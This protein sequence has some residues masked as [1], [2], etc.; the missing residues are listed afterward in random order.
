[1]GVVPI[2]GACTALPAAGKWEQITPKGVSLPRAVVIDPFDTATIWVGAAPAG[3]GQPAG[4]GGLYKSTDC[5][6]TW[7]HVNTGAHG[8]E[9]DNARLWS[10]AVDP[11]DKG[12][13]YVVGA[14]GPGGLWKSTNGGVDW[15][16][17]FPATS[18]LAKTVQ[19]NFV[20]SVS[21]GPENHLHLV[22]GTH[23]DCTGQY[24]P[25]CMAES[26]DGGATWKIFTT[27]FLKGWGEQTGPYVLDATTLVFQTLTD[28]LWLTTDHGANWT[29][30]TP[31]GVSGATGGE[32]THRPLAPSKD[33]SFYLPSYNQGGLLRSTDVGRS[34]SRVANAPH[35][36]YELGIA[37][38]GG[39]LYLGDYN[40][41]T[42]AVTKE[43]DPTVWTTIASPPPP[44]DAE[45]PKAL[46]Y[47]ETH[48]LLYSSN[49]S[50][51]LWR[52]VTP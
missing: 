34:W 22:V 4:Q 7:S 41:K 18:E 51:G 29:N 17:L 46:E 38:G 47:D 49:V 45:G 8:A 23:A 15:A 19:Y 42:Y 40:G 12:V 5:G 14:Y 32:Y 25:T 26:L 52:V 30:V 33:G 2:V 20:G 39:S 28:G 35:G 21:M 36:S 11:V 6:S 24:A 3:S 9:I 16:Q 27:P 44:A 37:I 43:A 50:G 13:V 1:M 10:L 31:A 48:H